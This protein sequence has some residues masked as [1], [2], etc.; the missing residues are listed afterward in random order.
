MRYYITLIRMA[1]FQNN[2]NTKSVEDVEQPELSFIAGG[3]AKCYTLKGSLT[4][5]E[6]N[7]DLLFN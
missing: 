3:N 6:L 5:T 2:Y 4:I 7:K 1:K